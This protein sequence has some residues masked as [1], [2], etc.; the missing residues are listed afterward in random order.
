MFSKLPMYQRVG[1]VAYK[2]D[3]TNIVKLCNF[4]GN[5][6]LQYP[7]I[8]V[9]GTNGKGSVSHLLAAAFQSKKYKTGLYVSPHYKDYRERIKI[10]GKY[11][12]VKFVVEF[13]EDIKPL[14]EEINPS[15]FEIN[16]A[17]AFAYFAS[18]QVD[19][20]IIETGLGGRLDS[21]NI[22]KPLLSVITNI[23]YDH[24]SLLG[25]TLPEIAFEKAGIIKEG[26]PVVIGEKQKEVAAVFEKRAFEHNAKLTF[27]TDHFKAEQKDSNIE[28]DTFDIYKDNQLYLPD[29][30][31]ELKGSFQLKNMITVLAALDQYNEI[32]PDFFKPE[33][34]YTCFANVKTLTNFMGRWQILMQKPLVICDSGHNEA[35]IAYVVEQLNSINYNKLH[36]VLGVVND[37]D[38]DKMLAMLPQEALYYFAKANIPRGL[39]AKSLKEKAKRF[40][41]RGKSFSSVIKA[42]KAA[43]SNAADDDLVFIGGSTFVVAEVL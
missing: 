25:E 24:M 39:D 19:I 26:I 5:P 30:K 35:G 7:T 43:V 34:I 27:A 1:P 16:V 17:M 13:I 38:I 42:Y 29:L 21:T 10:D 31:F 40:N 15:F 28:Y 20:A 2:K 41:L 22:V 8:H 3:L 32:H 18:K 4:L 37:K 9:A 33:D 11:V 23:S 36:F 12:P 6:H 14:I